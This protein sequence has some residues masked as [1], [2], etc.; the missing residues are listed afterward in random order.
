MLLKFFEKNDSEIKN[1]KHF[2]KS[3]IS[4]IW[5]YLIINN[6]FESFRFYKVF[7]IFCIIINFFKV[8]E[9]FE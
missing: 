4:L 2:A 6:S 3:L 7:L 5:F 9:Y 8:F 1:L